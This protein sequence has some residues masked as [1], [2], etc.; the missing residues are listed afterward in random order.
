[1]APLRFIEN[2]LKCGT[3]T[4]A[5]WSQLYDNNCFIILYFVSGKVEQN[6]SVTSW[7]S[8]IEGALL[9]N[10]ASLVSFV[11]IISS[12]SRSNM[13]DSIWNMN[14]EIIYKLFVFD[15]IAYFSGALR[16]SPCSVGLC[17]LLKT[18]WWPLLHMFWILLVISSLFIS[19]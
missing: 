19:I 2:V 17:S 15:I 4:F 18:V 6:E 16:R 11:L 9:S 1:M 12:P 7:I 13:C 3:A 14:I 5:T 10:S 8:S